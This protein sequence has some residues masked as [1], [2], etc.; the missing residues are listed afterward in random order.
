[1]QIPEQI[2]IGGYIVGVKE[3]ENIMHDRRELGNYQPRTQEIQLDKANTD[4]QKEETFMHEIIEAITT[5]YDIDIDH[6]KLSVIATVLHQVMKDNR[7]T[8]F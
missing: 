7:L 8:F 2:K 3:V 5:I 4:Q 1:M 6:H